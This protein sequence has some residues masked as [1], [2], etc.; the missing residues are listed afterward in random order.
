MNL[1]LWECNSSATIVVTKSMHSRGKFHAA[2]DAAS[3]AG[4]LKGRTGSVLMKLLLDLE[5]HLSFAYNH[6]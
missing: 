4:V 1:A 6:G 5:G 2:R 3:E